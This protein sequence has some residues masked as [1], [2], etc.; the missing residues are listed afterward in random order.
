MHLK[1]E[2]IYKV[3]IQII[4]KNYSISF[5]SRVNFSLCKLISLTS[6]LP[7]WPSGKE[8]TS[9]EGDLGSIPGSGRFP[10]EVNGNPPQYYCL[11]NPMGRGAQQA[12]VHG[13]A[14]ESDL[15]NIQQIK[16]DFKIQGT[17]GLPLWLSSKESTCHRSHRFDP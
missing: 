16:L 2:L 1:Q 15:A 13:V 11:G 10:R 9:K 14:K 6:G 4:F 7:T 17:Y 8:S 5:Y 3:Y 12:T